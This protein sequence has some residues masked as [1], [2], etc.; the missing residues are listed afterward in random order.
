M[1]RAS[2]SWLASTSSRILNMMAVRLAS[3]YLAH[4]FCALTDEAT[5]WSRSALLADS[6]SAV[7]LPVA[8]FSTGMV[9]SGFPS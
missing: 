7:T 3:E 8:G 1:A 6:S 5:A 9:W 4:S 2:S